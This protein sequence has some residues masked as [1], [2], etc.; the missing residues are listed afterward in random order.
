M[1]TVLSRANAI[2]AFTLS[3]LAGLTFLCFLSTVLKD[4]RG[5]VS[6][7]TVKAVVKNVPDFSASRLK[8]DLGFVTLDLKADLNHLFNWNVKQLFLYLIAEYTTENNVIN[9]VV[10]WDKIIR[11]NENASINYQKINPKYYF[12]DDGNGL[13]GNSN[14]TLYLSW[15]IIPNAGSL[16]N[17]MGDGRHKFSFP[18]E[19]TTYRI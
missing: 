12:W 6:I 10:L 14:I 1:N 19:Y 2:F 15:N 5:D 7:S 13:R 9:Q 3:V 8:N 11:R 16:P 17:I 4:Y 18:E